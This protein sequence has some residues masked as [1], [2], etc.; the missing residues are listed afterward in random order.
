MTWDEEFESLFDLSIFNDVR[1][2]VAKILSGDRLLQS[3]EEINAF[4]ENYDREPKLDAPLNEKILARTLK[5]IIE[6]PHKKTAL[7]PY[8]RYNL[9]K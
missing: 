6:N 4:F 9:L 5:S 3:F 8:D 2:P 7:L 1:I